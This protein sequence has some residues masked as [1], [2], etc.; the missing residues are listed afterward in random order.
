MKKVGRVIEIINN[1]KILINY[2][3][4]AGAKKGDSVRIIEQGE[5]ITDPVTGN[6]LGTY[7]AI[8]AELEITTVY[9]DFSECQ[10]IRRS[11]ISPFE[12]PLSRKY[13]T[14]STE[15]FDVNKTQET[16]RKTPDASEI[17]VGDIV[18]IL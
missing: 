11:Y 16:H 7:D 1:M 18:E 15:S 9:S 5:E 3:A 6:F 17:S 14:S 8:K 13:N 2:G 4:N 10:K 12:S